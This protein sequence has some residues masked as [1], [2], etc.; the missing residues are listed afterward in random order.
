MYRII[1][2]DGR[3]YGPVTA[4]QLRQWISD[5]RAVAQTKA[6]AE[7]V[8]EWKALSEFPE[9]ADAFAA[10]GAAAPPPQLLPPGAGELLA[11]EI[12]AR[13]YSLDIGSC[14]SRACTL[15]FGRFWL[16]FG[17][18][19]IIFVISVVLS[20][21]PFGTLILAYVFFG[22]LYWLFLKLAR[23]E[24]ADLGDAFSGFSLTFV[25]LMLF[26]IVGQLLETVG[27]LLCILP[28]IYLIVAWMFAPLLIMDK[29]LDFWDAMELSRK[30]VTRHWWIL[31]ALFLLSLLLLLAGSLVLCVGFFIAMPITTAA[32]VYAYEDIFGQSKPAAV[33]PW[34]APPS[35]PPANTAS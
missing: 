3:E 29:R 19:F 27:L 9:F 10:K 13:D 22:G 21:I 32:A 16:T 11:Q 6:R 20:W 17:A 35:A 5:R 12:L 30:V 1:G 34:P 33:I 4:E 18:T 26:S 24:Q 8:T 2:A 15:V 14:F 31:F 7:D 28:G 25:P 23:G